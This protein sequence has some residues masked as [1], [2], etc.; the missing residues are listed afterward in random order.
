MKLDFQRG[1]GFNRTTVITVCELPVKML[2]FMAYIFN[3][4]V[5]KINVF[6]Y[7]LLQRQFYITWN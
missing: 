4:A 2:S 7:I 6:S 1:M 3:A 5:F